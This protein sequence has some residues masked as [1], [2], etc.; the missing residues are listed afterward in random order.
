MENMHSD[1]GGTKGRSMSRS[2]FNICGGGGGRGLQ[3][4]YCVTIKFN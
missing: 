1:V 2:F 3:D 4:S